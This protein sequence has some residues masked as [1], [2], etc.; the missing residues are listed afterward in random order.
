MSSRSE[1]DDLE[2]PLEVA[3]ADPGVAVEAAAG[4]GA[5]AERR[6]R[7]RRRGAR[8]GDI[9]SSSQWLDSH[10]PPLLLLLL[11]FL[12]HHF[13]GIT[14]FLFLTLLLLK[15]DDV[16]KVQVAMREE[17]SIAKVL[18]TAVAA[19]FGAAIPCLL[20]PRQQLWRPLVFLIRAKDVTGFT[21][22]VFK[23]GCP[24]VAPDR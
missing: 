22:V 16:L 15:A 7:N 17:R 2:D 10:V 1:G 14:V 20:L 18:P 11:F 9:H 21:G 24:V 8:M 5:G 13:V 6:R 23:V 3:A 19:G 4:A 12:A